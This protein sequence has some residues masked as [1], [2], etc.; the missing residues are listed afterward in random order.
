MNA[1]K[2]IKSKKSNEKITMFYEKHFNFLV[3]IA[4]TRLNDFHKANDIV[5]DAFI[6]FLNK[7]SDFPEY[8]DK[9][10]YGILK[11]L[12]L[13]YKTTKSKNDLLLESITENHLFSLDR[14]LD[15]RDVKIILQDSID[16]VCENKLEKDIIKFRYLYNY[17]YKEISNHFGCS[18]NKI[19]YTCE[20][21]KKKL[22]SELSKKGI[23]NI[24]CITSM[25]ILILTMS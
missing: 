10:I 8:S 24:K 1:Q 16:N 2:N 5:Q 3:N 17:S 6:I 4:L 23:R 19:V 20:N 13:K 25:I 9:L 18:K 22:K 12:I 14:N 21:L 15:N 11:K 7:Y